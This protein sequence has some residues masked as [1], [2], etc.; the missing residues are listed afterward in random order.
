MSELSSNDKHEPSNPERIAQYQARYAAILAEQRPDS[1]DQLRAAFLEHMKGCEYDESPLLNAFAWFWHGWAASSGARAARSAERA[2]PEQVAN[3]MRDCCYVPGHFDAIKHLLYCRWC[4]YVQGHPHGHDCPMT[5]LEPNAAQVPGAVKAGDGRD[6]QGQAPLPPDTTP[7][8]APSH[9][10]SSELADR[11]ES[12]GAEATYGPWAWDQRGEKINEWALGTAF[13]S[14]E[15][16]LAG[17]FDDDDAIYDM[18]VCQT[19]G[20]TV[21]YADPELI[22]AL[23]NNL[24][25][26]I[27]ALRGARSATASTGRCSC[28]YPVTSCTRDA[29]D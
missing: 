26:I 10:R 15:K 12:L 9:A 6:T 13:D 17:R 8:A 21:N 24:P 23:R 20:A 18:Q 25:E 5:L 22:C 19:E 7:A 11:L 28:G 16:P 27:A 14:N 1:S 2:I 4:H 3:V 29:T